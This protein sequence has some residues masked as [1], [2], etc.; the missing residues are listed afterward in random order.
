M[1]ELTNK[2]VKIFGMKQLWLISGHNK[3]ICLEGLRKSTIHNHDC[4]SSGRDLNPRHSKRKA[5]VLFDC[6]HTQLWKYF[7]ILGKFDMSG[8]LTNN[9]VIYYGRIH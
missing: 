6:V 3:L 1:T 2:E 7:V 4:P 5:G 9:T 8:V